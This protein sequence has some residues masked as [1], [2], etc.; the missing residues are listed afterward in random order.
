MNPTVAASSLTV[1]ICAFNPRKDHLEQ[2]LKALRGQTLPPG[3]WELLLVDNNS[4]TP[5]QKS[6]NLSW[7]PRARVVV[8]TSSGIAA[9]RSR[10]MREY[11]SD[12][13]M[14]VD[15]DNILAPNYLEQALAI[16]NS[17][18]QMGAFSGQLHGEFE[19]EPPTAL[20]PYLN[21]L[22]LREFDHDQWSNFPLEAGHTPVTAGMCLRRAVTDAYLKTLA[23]RPPGITVGSSGKNFLRGEDDDICFSAQSVNLGVGM[24]KDLRLTHLIPTDRLT[25]DYLCGLCEGIVYSGY[26]V[27]YLWKKPIRPPVHSWRWRFGYWRMRQ[28]MTAVEK[29]F[30][31][32]TVRA[33]RRAWETI[34]AL[35]K[36]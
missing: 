24:F 33:E 29:R 18:P 11:A 17:F 32:A 31:D 30:A 10:A 14:F 7:H 19:T 15:D 5:L 13:L 3:Q 26:V 6:T 21:L 9:A 23:A 27:S 25:E 1:A 2:T 16:A 20:R 35:E 22:A 36:S 8:E 12:L 4:S 34:R 28:K